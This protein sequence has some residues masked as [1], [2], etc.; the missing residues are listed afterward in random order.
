MDLQRQCSHHEIPIW[1]LIQT[2][3]KGLAHE[4]QISIDVAVGGALMGKIVAQAKTLLKEMTVNSY[5]WYSERV[6]SKVDVITS[7]SSKVDVLSQQIKGL[8]VGVNV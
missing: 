5:H 2:F 7:L 4:V 8:S 3:Y 6:T 1:L